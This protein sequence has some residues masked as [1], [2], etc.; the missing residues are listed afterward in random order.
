[1][2]GTY[3]LAVAFG[4]TVLPV[5]ISNLKELTITQ[6]L[7]SFLPTF[8][9]RLIDNTGTFTHLVPLD[10]SMSKISIEL[11][12]DQTT[13]DK[14]VFVFD[15]YRVKPIGDQPTPASIYDITGLLSVPGLFTPDYSR[16]FSGS[17][18]E[19]LETLALDELGADDT[20]VSPSLDY[21]L[22][23]I[24]PMWND[25]F[26]LRYLTKRLIGSNGEYNFKC[27]IQTQNYNNI[28]MFKSLLEMMTQP[29]SYKFNLSDQIYQDRLPIF[30]WSIFDNYKLYGAFGN[31]TQEYT[32]FDWNTGTFTFNNLNV[33]D[34]YSM[35]DYFLID[36]SDLTTSNEMSNSGRSNDFDGQFQGWAEASYT[37]RL[38]NLVQMWITTQGLP[39]AI[40]GQTVQ[41]FFPQGTLNNN[42]YGYTAQGFYTIKSVIHNCGSMFVTKLLLS[43]QGV[44]T[45]VSTTLLPAK[46][47]KRV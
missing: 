40:P 6:D 14:N 31:Q 43:R 33:Q 15:V 35:S 36:K 28:F 37:D 8:R 41:I 1:M 44:D 16:G 19:T 4:D 12:L 32:Y 23:I 29:V 13:T 26:L 25:S 2:L 17:V 34:Y 46:T 20:N 10:K 11:A 30:S 27:A 9:L 24:Q 3:F 47:Y 18:K 22:N 39:N 42:L 21:D 38:N 5:N 45:N 7:N